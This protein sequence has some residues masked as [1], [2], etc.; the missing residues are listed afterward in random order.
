MKLHL[1]LRL[2][3]ALAA[4][5]SLAGTTAFA[6]EVVKNETIAS[7]NS[8]SAWTG[9]TV[10]GSGDVAVW[11]ASSALGTEDAPLSLGGDATWAG[12]K[13]TTNALFIGAAADGMT[14]NLGGEGMN[15]SAQSKLTI[16]GNLHLTANQT[17]WSTT[18]WTETSVTVRGSLTGSSNLSFTR[19]GGMVVH[20][21]GDVSGYTG[22]IDMNEWNFLTFSRGLTNGNIT[23]A[24]NS[25]GGQ[26]RITVLDGAD[27]VYNHALTMDWTP[28]GGG[29]MNVFTLS[30]GTLTLAG[31]NSLNGS[32]VLANDALLR[33]QSGEGSV[34]T[35]FT[36][37]LTITGS[38]T[39]ELIGTHTLNSANGSLTVGSGVTLDVTQGKLALSEYSN[40][41]NVMVVQGTLKLSNF[42]YN[43]SIS[44]LADYARCRKIDGGTIVIDGAS[45]N[46]ILGFTVT[47]NGGSFLM[48]Q[49]GETLTLNGNGNS[50]TI[51]FNGNGGRL[52]LG[53]AGNITLNGNAAQSAISGSGTIVK[54][55]SGTLTLNHQSTAFLGNLILEEGTLVLDNDQAL[56]SLSYE[57]GTL[58]LSNRSLANMT[59]S[60]GNGMTADSILNAGAFKG[61]V[62]LGNAGVYNLD[63]TP[64]FGTGY[65]VETDTTFTLTDSVSLLQTGGGCFLNGGEHALTLTGSGQDFA[66]GGYSGT[67]G[68]VNG[69]SVAFDS[70]GDINLSGNTATSNTFTAGGAV[71]ATESI[72]FADTGSIT[73]SGNQAHNG[74][75]SIDGVER[76]A[77]TGLG[78]ALTAQEGISFD[79][80]GN[81]TF[82]NNAAD[83][84]GGAIYDDGGEIAMTNVGNVVFSGNQAGVALVP[85]NGSGGA[86]YEG[87][88]SLTVDG[89]GSVTFT[90]NKAL[91]GSGGAVYA[92]GGILFANTGTLTFESNTASRS[93]GALHAE[94]DNISMTD[95]T[96]T[97]ES[98]IVFQDNTS[99]GR[100]G[101][102]DAAGGSVEISSVTGGVIFSSNNA[103]GTLNE[104]NDTGNGGAIY[105][106][107]DVTISGV[108]GD[109][110][111]TGNT[112][113]MYGGAIYAFNVTLSAD[114]GNITFD[115]NTQ[116]GGTR[117]SAIDTQIDGSI[118]TFDAAAGRE[119][120]FYD[121][122]TGGAENLASINLNTG[123]EMTGTILFSGAHVADHASDTLD[124][125]LSRYSDIYAN[126]IFGGGKLVLEQ[127][128][129]FG[130]LSDNWSD[131]DIPTSFV[132]TGG[133]ID[134]DATSTLS[135]QSIEME[136]TTLDALKGGRLAGETVAFGNGTMKIGRTLTVDA[137][138]GLTFNS[139]AILS[140]DMTGA[141]TTDAQLSITSGTLSFGGDACFITLENA[142]GLVV[143]TSY[144]L[145]EWAV[146]N[147]EI[148]DALFQLDENLDL[149]RNSYTLEVVGNQLLLHVNPSAIGSDWIW[150]GS[151][152]AWSGASC[153]GWGTPEL[154]DGTPD[155]KDVFFT[156][157]GVTSGDTATVTISGTVTP[158]SITVAGA[159]NYV[160]TSAG[161]GQISG[162]STL[163]KTGSGTLT[164]QLAN[165]YTGD[166]ILQGG[167]I[168]IEAVGALGSG[169]LQVE[170]NGSLALK[171]DVGNK[172]SL[173]DGKTLT[174]QVQA[175]SFS[176][177]GQIAGAGNLVKTGTGT[178]VLS[179]GGQDEAT[180][181]TFTGN[182]TVREGTLQLGGIGGG[183]KA[184]CGVLGVSN[185]S[186]DR[187][188]SVE[189]GATLDMHGQKDQNYAVTIAG[190][191]VG[192]LGALV[193]MGDAIEL[194]KIT[195][196][197]IT[198][199]A[200]AGMGGTGDFGIIARQY[201]A[202]TLDLAGHTLAKVGTNTVTLFNTLITEG[203]LEVRE[204][205]LAIGSGHGNSS[206][207]AVSFTIG[208]QGRFE[209]NGTSLTVKSLSG[210]GSLD[211]GG[212]SGTLAVKT[213]GGFGGALA[214][215]GTLRLD[216]AGEYNLD[217][218]IGDAVNINAVGGNV[219]LTAANT[220][221]GTLTIGD[222]K[223]A[224][225]DGSTWAGAVAG[226]GTLK[227]VAGSLGTA[228]NPSQVADTVNV[229]ID[230]SPGAATTPNVIQVNGLA[231]DRLTSIVLGA[232]SSLK[233][234]SGDITVGGDGKTQSLSLTI[235]RANVGQG[236]A[237][238]A[239]I[240]QTGN[241]VI[242]NGATLN[243]SVDAVLDLLQQ[244][245]QE[246]S[247][248]YLTLTSGQLDY[249]DYAHIVFDRNL[250]AYGIVVSRTDGG[251]LVLSGQTKDIY[252]TNDHNGGTGGSVIDNYN[253]LG[254]FSAVAIQQNHELTVNLAGA[255]GADDLDNG[256][257][258]RD[259]TAGSGSLLHVVNTGE[260]ADGLNNAVVRL[261]GGASDGELRGDNGVTFVIEGDLTMKK[262]G[263]ITATDGD[264]SI[265]GGTL[266]LQG[267]GSNIGQLT[268]DSAAEGDGLAIDGDT[269]IGTLVDGQG[270]TVTIGS[271]AT[272]TL[273]AGESVLDGSASSIVG[274]GTLK[275]G[276]KL[277]LSGG[278]NLRGVGLD[279]GSKDASVHLA[280]TTE[281]TVSSL[282]GSGTLQG[283]LGSRLTVQTH[284][285]VVSTFDG[286]LSG[287]LA[288]TIAGQGTQAFRGQ[289]IGGGT[290]SL[291]V[292]SG[293]GLQLGPDAA[294]TNS[295]LW[296]DNL[297]LA[298]GSQ[299]SLTL[300]TDAWASSVRS[301]AAVNAPLIS[302][303]SITIEEGAQI[304]LSSLATNGRLTAGAEY[305]LMTA[306]TGVG[307]ENVVLGKDGML[308]VNTD[309]AA[310]VLIEEAYLQK[311]GN[312]IVLVTQRRKDNLYAGIATTSNSAAGA[313]LVWNAV[314]EGLNAGGMLEAI[315]D[316]LY[317]DMTADPGRA[318][319]T[320]AAVA[321]SAVTSLGMAQKDA[322]RDQ[323]GMIRNRLTNMGVD[324]IVLNEDMP[325]F[326]M[327]MQATGN[328]AKQD[329]HGDESGYTLDTWGGTIGLDLDVTEA[330]TLGGAFTAAYGDLDANA[331]ETATGD[332]DSYYVNLFARAQVHRWTHKVIV[333]LGINDAKLT[334][335]VDYGAGSYRARG[336]TRGAGYGAMYELT[337]DTW[338]N[339]EETAVLQPLLN[340]SIL[341][342]QMDAYN[343]DG[344]TAGDAALRVGKQDMTVGTAALG[345]RLAGQLSENALG[346]TSFGEFRVNVAQDMGD[347]RSQ[348]NVGFI[349]T[350][351]MARSVRSA[352]EGRTALQIG[353]G[354]TIPIEEAASI[355][356]DVNADF[357][358]HAA[359]VNGSIGYR[360]D[361]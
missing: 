12:I 181:N 184:T 164:I 344:G 129:T 212:A 180:A 264:V 178:L 110:S 146:E 70:L 359:S 239:L 89:A 234:V 254:V 119:I 39:V 263:F 52:T 9:G 238:T 343:E 242:H 85:K 16:G 59:I 304:S 324:A 287:P 80:T 117:L 210:T 236:G 36:K 303:G 113:A 305:T 35:T 163:T 153:A 243:L 347:D 279:I 98:A 206:A 340:L 259:L 131:E 260:N 167:V 327:W 66:L 193:N 357:R 48:Q 309:G 191:G 104:A 272:L 161:D 319:R 285:G 284:Q 200:D 32:I 331:A 353:A 88:G 225:I 99:A 45:H 262:T 134:I 22:T 208:A 278:S 222:G 232:D 179:A 19:G 168:A 190:N 31:T 6:A 72:S 330:L 123:A 265:V 231:G 182:I 101:A 281:H 3:A 270:G 277:S 64:T 87:S 30:S 109:V 69:S 244:H 142:D 323:M 24:P 46:S 91:S 185:I 160:F 23:A 310:F 312:D 133:T 237:G 84:S 216:G 175:G 292:A 215:S 108:T 139:G 37:A 82:E 11:D 55:G 94:L 79:T 294:G 5:W 74:K 204:G 351:S 75:T 221:A 332:F 53:G 155:G 166:T 71:T 257:L 145:M 2:L 308:A 162:N 205:T 65:L 267:A 14:V 251:S 274:T 209:L 336:N 273:G 280:D 326:H 170:N 40:L 322:L 214:G 122:V 296:L 152:T 328:Y 229:A 339:E 13:L 290:V 186:S 147:G 246:G 233:G 220:S 325:Y 1:P 313:S 107:N 141:S 261:Q 50:P 176:Y 83:L 140:F 127:G 335:T 42:D 245:K 197:K 118:F 34:K 171:A 21:Q 106:Y 266:T 28:G 156:E 255:P 60:F 115:G 298:A 301:R 317:A 321:G 92:T 276:G 93:G 275:V 157:S 143:D 7:L 154:T 128:V 306:T 256:V 169:I 224:T 314:E 172:A 151:G 258:I 25:G 198:L 183:P 97:G 27:F 112:A 177:S 291:S 248:S 174:I 219:T 333:C 56:V 130:H 38:G 121:P 125:D 213:A 41:E 348:S 235:N 195:F 103:A 96:A 173:H 29:G 302:A 316:A 138:E 120:R 78:G 194:D 226:T 15:L 76:E 230:A 57:G 188:I 105:A 307:G 54:T 318:A 299:T 352:K 342:T 329:S 355:F 247:S 114:G 356:F 252:D 126:T 207:E 293:A 269:F 111:F 218:V 253:E 8:D 73:M 148:T 90:G 18:N 49:A 320:L 240:E 124:A 116:L 338:L 282:S 289:N 102:I 135:A 165:N 33:F 288:V 81:L 51:V 358:A 286:A 189:D 349:G 86:I 341:R 295:T 150:N 20:F 47:E 345:I 43:G 196:P 203:S 77:L 202:A 250:A 268:L 337:F 211:L 300:D 360:Y 227:L 132:A 354:L 361:F 228:A 4:V 62:N 201:G 283:S 311:V 158:A 44:S 187:L 241:L 17:W 137:Q 159:K 199:T 217:G 26:S 61:T 136:N 149:S 334:R 58:D 95:V 192:N 67:S 271:H 297:H 350:P 144:V 223:T 100:G 315:N 249:T 346:R 63:G 68:A 10:P